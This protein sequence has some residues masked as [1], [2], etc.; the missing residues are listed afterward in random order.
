LTSANVHQPV[1][2]FAHTLQCR[3]EIAW[4]RE[5]PR[6]A[7]LRATALRAVRTDPVRALVR[8]RHARQ[9]GSAAA[10]GIRSTWP[11]ARRQ[12]GPQQP[13]RRAIRS[14]LC[15]ACARTA[16]CGA[17][18]RKV[19]LSH[20][21]IT[22]VA[23]RKVNVRE[24]NGARAAEVGGAPLCLVEL[25]M[26]AGSAEPRRRTQLQPRSIR[27]PFRHETQ[28]M[29]LCWP[30]SGRAC[31]G[32]LSQLRPAPVA[33]ARAPPPKTPGGFR[34]AFS[35]LMVQACPPGAGWCPEGIPGRRMRRRPGIFAARCR[36]AKRRLGPLLSGCT[37]RPRRTR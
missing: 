17:T 10:S 19:I 4:P 34:R 7:N 13:A 5:H 30:R 12:A 3:P 16:L 31:A 1:L 36:G 27:R 35:L 29:P 23:Y 33:V 18:S 2:A 14:G 21:E 8:A 6:S 24:P 11:V 22:L 25:R 37:V 9:P 20:I 28:N 15:H 32:P 26:P